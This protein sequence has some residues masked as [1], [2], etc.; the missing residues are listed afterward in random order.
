MPK[1]PKRPGRMHLISP[2]FPHE[3]S[4]FARG[5]NARLRSEWEVTLEQ[6]HSVSSYVW[7][8]GWDAAGVYAKKKQLELPCKPDVVVGV[9]YFV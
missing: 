6:D 2:Y 8:L 7:N 5:W 1:P 4:N 9:G 3:R